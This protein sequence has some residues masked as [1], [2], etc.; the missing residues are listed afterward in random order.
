[1]IDTGSPAALLASLLSLLWIGVAAGLDRLRGLHPLHAALVA[2]ALLAGAALLAWGLQRA[3]IRRLDRVPR[4]AVGPGEQLGLELRWTLPGVLLGLFWLPVALVRGSARLLR[5]I[6]RRLRREGATPAG[7]GG[8]EEGGRESPEPPLLVASLGPTFLLAALVATGLYL[9]GRLAEPLLAARLGLADGVSPWWY[10]LLG[11]RPELGWYLP[12][13]RFPFAA[14]LAALLFWLLVWSLAAT[15][16]RFA[17]RRHLGRDLDGERDDPRVLASWRRWCGLSGLAEPDRSFRHWAVWLPAAALPLVVVGWASLEAVP[18]RTRPGEVALALVLWL[19]WTLDLVLTGRDRR[20]PAA[21]AER[22]DATVANGWREVTR[23]L[24]GRLQVRPPEPY[25][26]RP[27]EPLGRSLAGVG[28]LGLLSP[29]L[30]ELLPPPG[31]LVPMQR[32]LLT[33]LSYRAYGHAGRPPAPGQLTLGGGGAGEADEAGEGSRHRLVLAPEDSGKTTLAL[34]A[35]ANHALRH[36]RASLVVVPTPERAEAL[37]RR[38]H[39]V[40]EPSTLRWN[41]R[42]RSPGADLM[43]DLSRGIVPDVVVVGLDD[44]VTT[45]LDDTDTFGPFLARL[46]LVVIDDV[47]GFHGPPEV[48]AQLAFRRLLL[49]SAELAP[50]AELRGQGEE[51]PGPQVLILG[52]GSMHETS[53]W[54]RSLTGTEA[55]VHRFGRTAAEARERERS[56]LAASGLEA[57][58]E[59]SSPAV[60]ARQ[61]LYRLRD[62]RDASG[63]Q[64]RIH[65]LVAA[66]EHEAVPWHYRLCGDGRRD[67]GRGPLALRE[68]PSHHTAD[69]ARAAVLLLAGSWS[70]VERELVR[71][72]RAGCTFN[73]LRHRDGDPPPAGSAGAPGEPIA[74]ITATDPDSEMAWTQLDQRFSLAPV[75]DSLPRPVMRPPTGVSWLPHLSAE[76]TQHRT[77]VADLLDVFGEGAAGILRSLADDHLL[78]CEGRTDV[79][80]KANRYVDRLYVRALARAVRDE[81]EFQAAGATPVSDGLLPPPVADVRLAASR[82]VTVRERT[83]GARLGRTDAA[84]VHLVFYPGR[85]FES[86]EGNFVVLRRAGAGD[87]SAPVGT[88]PDGRPEG[89]AEAKH[90][91]GDVL[92]EP[93]L[94]DEVSSPRRRLGFV[95]LGKAADPDLRAAAGGTFSEPVPVLFG[96][97]PFRLALRPV[98][99]TVDHV[100]TYRLGPIHREVRQRLILDRETREEIARRSLETVALVLWPNPEEAAP[101]APALDLPRARLLAAVLRAVLPSAYRGAGTSLGVAVQPPE[102]GEGEASATAAGGLAILLYEAEERGNGA[103]RAIHRDGVDVLL[104]LCRLFL[105]RVLSYDR[106]RALHDEWGDVEECLAEARLD[107]LGDAEAGRLA[108]ERRRR[109][110]ADRH[111]LLAWLDSRLRPEGGAEL[112][113][114]LAERFGSGSEVGEGDLID[115]GRVWFSRDHAVTDLLWGKHRWRLSG[116]GEAALDVG[117]DRGTA[118]AA[119]AIGAPRPAPT[120][121]PSGLG[122]VH[123]LPRGGGDDGGEADDRSDGRP[124]TSAP[125]EGARV[126]ATALSGWLPGSWFPLRRLARAVAGHGSG[127]GEPAPGDGELR[128]GGPCDR[129]IRFVQGIPLTADDPPSGGVRSPV[130]TL[131]AR[132]GDEPAKALLLALL[133]RSRGVPAGVFLSAERRR[134]LAAVVLP[135][136]AGTGATALREWCGRRGLQG[137]PPLW[138]EAPAGGP[139]EEPGSAGGAPRLFVPVPV[140]RY[141][142]VGAAAVEDPQQWAFL[143]LGP[144]PWAERVEREEREDAAVAPGAEGDGGP[145]DGPRTETDARERHGGEDAPEGFDD[146]PDPPDGR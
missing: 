17:L 112:E 107:K 59:G 91:Q 34:L 55:A 61:F 42:L 111:A 69:P 35:V 78:T 28:G 121:D 136:A 2:A 127:G 120:G 60:G 22:S 103:A 67:L 74:L 46:G 113:Q 96:R 66:C 5:G 95:D 51:E 33:I 92:V 63:E 3:L 88:G 27:V 6:V 39:R 44:L 75:I 14:A 31:D 70:E 62:F 90:R 15:G 79:D 139:P 102:P 85:I 129:L 24:E 30:G 122:P 45:I 8:T 86:R 145:N 138:A 143:P 114:E 130:A 132:G 4:R 50:D 10:L 119:G 100:A 43:R 76:L 133:L 84:S 65:D 135:E 116:G 47:E 115:L 137:P 123:H 125:G 21:E 72:Q 117:F 11:R 109:D 83:S 23:H 141:G 1:M 52:C 36:T 56:E 54:A 80:P 118:L 106:L 126:V 101:E 16:I 25:A 20:G 71:L 104:R 93:L 9:A 53:K 37:H 12:F 108:A 41:V 32:H 26:V 110:E 58:E 13:D 134:A 38:F 49:R 57:R 94:G 99:V 82:S 131:L 142:P 81:D 89:A 144:P 124:A 7:G 64:L 105:E 68:E 146:E 97:E 98:R 18:Y 140:D 73:R 19:G 77:E 29:L 87:G 128:P 48:H 40:L